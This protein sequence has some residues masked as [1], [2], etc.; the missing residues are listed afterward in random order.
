MRPGRPAGCGPIQTAAPEHSRWV[1]D[2]ESAELNYSRRMAHTVIALYRPKP[3]REA[4]L[5]KLVAEHVPALRSFG[6]ATRA[7]VQLLR[8]SDGTLLEIFDWRDAAAVESAHGDPRVHALWGRFEELC[9]FVTLGGLPEANG[10]FPHFER[11]AS[12]DD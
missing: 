1:P 5:A 9:E 11:L 12:C 4:D 6:L 7:P 3:G 8:A 10:P 2:L